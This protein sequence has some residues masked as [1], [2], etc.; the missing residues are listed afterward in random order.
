MP[1]RRLFT[2]SARL[3]PSTASG[4]KLS[5]CA[6]VSSVS[7]VVTVFPE[8]FV[9]PR[10]RFFDDGTETDVLGESS[11]TVDPPSENPGVEGVDDPEP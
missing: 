2:L 11:G 7:I 3:I 5:N 9:W 10:F 4:N 6:S 8:N 1:L